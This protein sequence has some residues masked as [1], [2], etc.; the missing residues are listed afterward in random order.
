MAKRTR[1][2]TCGHAPHWG[3]GLCKKCYH[4]DWASKNAEKLKAYRAAWREANREREAATMRAYAEANRDAK[5]EYDRQ[6][7]LANREERIA[8]VKAWRQANP[9]RVKASALRHRQ[10]RYDPD[11][12]LTLEEWQ[13]ILAEFDGHCAYCDVSGVPLEQGAHGACLAWRRAYRFGT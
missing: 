3:K 7:Y 12:D 8:A 9:E 4:A 10:R 2:T 13:A 11:A 6:N 5:I 1:E